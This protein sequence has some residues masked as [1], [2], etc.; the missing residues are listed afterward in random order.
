MKAPMDKCPYC[1]NDYDFYTKD[2]IQGSS[3]FF[4][5]FKGDEEMD[6]G[7]MYDTLSHYKGKVA[8]CGKCN[9]QL[10]KIKD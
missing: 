6:N 8:Y 4:H 3:W 10:F 7:S 9:K 1:G 2:Y 5:S